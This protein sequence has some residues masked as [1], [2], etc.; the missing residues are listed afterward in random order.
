MKNN[1]KKYLREIINVK[2]NIYNRG[3]TIF[4]FF[5]GAL[6]TT[7]QHISSSWLTQRTGKVRPVQYIGI[8]RHLEQ[9]L[10]AHI[11]GLIRRFCV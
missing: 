3:V 11:S 5:V 7:P 9:L 6:C 2:D 4:F 1:Q 8:Q 10:R